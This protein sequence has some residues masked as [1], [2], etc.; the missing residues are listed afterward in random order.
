MLNDWGEH[1]EMTTRNSSKYEIAKNYKSHKELY[2]V[3][4]N[5]Y[6]NNDDEEMVYDIIEDFK[7]W[8]DEH[9]YFDADI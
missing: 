2:K 5:E 6:I 4:I 9:N 8:I 1:K 3:I 7:T